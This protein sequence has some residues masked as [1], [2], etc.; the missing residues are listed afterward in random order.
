MPGRAPA[1]QGGDDLDRGDLGGRALGADTGDQPSGFEHQQPRCSTS[2]RDSANPGGDHAWR[3]SAPRPPR[4][5]TVTPRPSGAAP[6]SSTTTRPSR[7]P[8][9]VVEGVLPP[10]PA[11]RYRT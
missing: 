2:I 10:Q 11:S 7:A 5:P 8:A 6:T 3:R 4:P 9:D 1:A